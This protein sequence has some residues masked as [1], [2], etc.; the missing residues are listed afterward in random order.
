MY[1]EIYT[2]PIYLTLIIILSILLGAGGLF[3]YQEYYNED[4]I[5]TFDECVKAR[6]SQQLL[7]YPGICTTKGGKQFTQP[8]DEGSTTPVSD[9]TTLAITDIEMSNG[10]YW[11]SEYQKKSGTPGTWIF[12]ENGKSSCWHDQKITCDISSYICPESAWVD[13]MPGPNQGIK[14]ECTSEFLTW[15]KSNCPEFQG[16]AY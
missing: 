1:N 6:G 8:I 4:D 7:I 16:A 13:C 12:T 11:G 2:K 9:D 5:T 14:Q 10:W 3:A 15:A